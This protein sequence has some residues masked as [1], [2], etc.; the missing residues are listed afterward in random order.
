MGGRRT[1]PPRRARRGGDVR[2]PVSTAEWGSGC[3]LAVKR[4]ALGPLGRPVGDGC[5]EHPLGGGEVGAGPRRGG[6]R[7]RAVLLRCAVAGGVVGDAVLPAAPQDAGPGAAEGA[8][9]ARVVVTAGARGGVAI[10]GPGVPVAG[11]GGGG[12]GGGSWGGGGGRGGGG[13]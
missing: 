11:G 1:R 4:F 5:A 12:G 9:R 3:R 6:D 2:R 13:G 10:G 7:D 8:D